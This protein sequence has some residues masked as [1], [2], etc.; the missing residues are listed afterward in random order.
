MMNANQIYWYIT[1]QSKTWSRHD[2]ATIGFSPNYVL[3]LC[4]DVADI[5]EIPS[6]CVDSKKH[7]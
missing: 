4:Q 3:L 6:L 5:E 1:D 2:A 7:S